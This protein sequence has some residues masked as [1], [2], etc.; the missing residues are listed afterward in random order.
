MT[1]LTTLEICGVF[2]Q[3]ET[4]GGHITNT[5]HHKLYNI[6]TASAGA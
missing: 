4:D 2:V 3:R 1:P 6:E 5:I